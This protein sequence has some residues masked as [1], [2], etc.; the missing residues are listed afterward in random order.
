MTRN[1]Y[2]QAHYN[3]WRVIIKVDIIRPFLS[4]RHYHALYRR[5]QHKARVTE[6]YAPL[7]WWHRGSRQ[8]LYKIRMLAYATETGSYLVLGLLKTAP[9]NDYWLW[10]KSDMECLVQLTN[11]HPTAYW[12]WFKCVMKC[13]V[14]L[15]NAHPTA[16]W[17][18]DKCVMEGVVQLTN[19][20]PTTYWLWD[21]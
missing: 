10:D 11:M 20:H 6:L 19:A 16:Y 3:A 12:L 17:L 5:W 9:I 8:L 2:T 15:T 4:R 13:L 1:E 14:Q 21:K 7:A 18:C